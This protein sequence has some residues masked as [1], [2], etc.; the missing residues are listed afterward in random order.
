MT[1]N[2]IF[3]RTEVNSMLVLGPYVVRGRMAHK[4]HP[5]RVLQELFDVGRGI[6]IGMK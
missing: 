1:S 2:V 6:G 5:D 3:P 4:Y